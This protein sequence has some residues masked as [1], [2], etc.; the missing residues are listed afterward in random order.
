MVHI[1]TTREAS[2]FLLAR[3]LNR[4]D[5]LKSGET[6]FMLNWMALEYKT[7]CNDGQKQQ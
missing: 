2:A 6:D 1:G 3:L 5:V 7:N 4:P